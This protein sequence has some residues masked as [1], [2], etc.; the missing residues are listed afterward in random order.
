MTDLRHRRALLGAL[1]IGL[2]LGAW[3]PWMRADQRATT[4][5]Y[6]DGKSLGIEEGFSAGY[7]A[8]EGA[9][10][11]CS[12]CHVAEASLAGVR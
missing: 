1:L 7:E 3:Q 6:L 5:A 11:S 10:T 2:L 8:A 12:Q 9:H 4:Q